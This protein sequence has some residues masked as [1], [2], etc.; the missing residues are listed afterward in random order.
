MSS[1]TK[2][3]QDNSF[4]GFDI[5]VTSNGMNE[6]LVIQ[7]DVNMINLVNFLISPPVLPSLFITP[8]DWL[9]SLQIFPF[10]VNVGISNILSGNLKVGGVVAKKNGGSDADIVKAELCYSN[11]VFNIGQAKIEPHFNNFADYNGYTKI[12]LYLPMFGFVEVN[13]N[14]VMNKYIQIRLSVDVVSGMG[15]YYICVSNDAIPVYANG[16]QSDDTNIERILATYSFQ[17]GYNIP[18]GSSDAPQVYRNIIGGAVKATTMAVGAYAISS[19]GATGGTSTTKT[20]KTARNPKTGRQ[21]TKGTKTTTRTY[22]GSNYQ[23]GKAVTECFDYGAQALTSMHMSSQ[24]DRVNNPAVLAEASESVHIIIYRPKLK[25][26]DSNYNHLYGQPLGEVKQLS[27]LSGYTEI[28]NLHIEDSGFDTAT[29][30]ELLMIMQ[31][32]SSGVLL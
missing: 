14:D 32:L 24:S 3:L 1:N 12:Q 17:I 18:I 19:L 29:Q 30:E 2:Y 31:E 27:E 5:R 22:D 10:N 23:F 20:V 16:V 8:R 4:G 6:S 13:P 7:N 28:A 9:T 26:V 21:I 11:R 15:V 25:P